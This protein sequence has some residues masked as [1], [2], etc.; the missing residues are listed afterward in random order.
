[1]TPNLCQSACPHVLSTV[2]QWASFCPSLLSRVF[3]SAKSGDSSV[4]S[5]INV[6]LSYLSSPDNL[7]SEQY[8]GKESR[9]D[10]T[11]MPGQA[12][13][14]FPGTKKEKLERARLQNTGIREV[15][16]W[17]AKF[18]EVDAV[19]CTLKYLSSEIDLFTLLVPISYILFDWQ[20]TLISTSKPS[21]TYTVDWSDGHTAKT[22]LQ[23]L[24][25]YF[26]SGHELRRNWFWNP[27]GDHDSSL[28]SCSAYGHILSVN[29][30]WVE[31]FCFG[32]K[33]SSNQNT[34]IVWESWEK[35]FSAKEMPL[36]LSWLVEAIIIAPN[37]LVL[38]LYA[39]G[40]AAGR[41]VWGCSAGEECILSVAA[42][43]ERVDSSVS[44]HA[45]RQ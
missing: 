39:D 17:Q 19:R 42:Q 5:S 1:M 34:C 45:R 15:R 43:Q 11:D 6:L 7:M 26:T 3:V 10:E 32:S 18:A 8:P 22:G 12:L 24:S 38:P 23:I 20:A 13:A 28:N 4:Y 31:C 37:V 30:L 40:C 41:L 27:R 29:I 21:K 25:H 36:C 35:L 9:G 33:T 44:Y 14:E 16:H 2:F